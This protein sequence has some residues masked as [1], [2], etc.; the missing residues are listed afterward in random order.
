[1]VREDGHASV[2]S[3][4]TGQASLETGISYIAPLY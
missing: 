2:V 3:W 4:R 1:M